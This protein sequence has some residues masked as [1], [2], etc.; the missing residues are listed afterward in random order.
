MEKDI[1]IKEWKKLLIDIGMSEAQLAK[2]VGQSPAN[3]NKK[4]ANGTIRFLE[5]SEILEQFGY[6]IIITKKD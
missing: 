1:F 4:I 2:A 5:L 6:K 3:L